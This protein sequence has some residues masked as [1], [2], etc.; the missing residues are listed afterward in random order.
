MLLVRCRRPLAEVVGTVG[1]Y[2]GKYGVALE[3]LVVVVN[4]LID[5]AV[6]VNELIDLAVLVNEEYE[7]NVLVVELIES[8]VV[9]KEL[10]E[11]FCH[12]LDIA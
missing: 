4:V 5:L 6:V 8:V 10:I 12:I 3:E 7:L 9:V 2:H 1:A 11:L